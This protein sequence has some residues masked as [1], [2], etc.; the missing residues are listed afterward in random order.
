MVA[1][2]ADLHG[3][4]TATQALEKD[5]LRRGITRIWCLGDVVGKGPSS[6]RCFDWAMQNCE[7]ILRGNWEDGIGR[8]LFKNDAFYRAQLGRA[9]LDAML[10]FP[11]E[12]H[13]QLAGRRLRLLHGRPAL[14]GLLMPEDREE[15]LNP[16]FEPD[17]DIVGYADCHRPGL[18][19][20]H[21][22]L[23]NTGSVGNGFG[24]LTAQYAILET[25]GDDRLSPI[26]LCFVSLPYDREEA[27]R[28]TFAQPQL[29]LGH[30]YVQEIRIGRYA[31]G[32]KHNRDS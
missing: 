27:V 8:E 28:E 9:R 2:I 14:K 22:L 18:R 3:N 19:T 26:D 4:Y 12:K 25:S 24:T 13:L 6:D 17:F 15:L 1:I 21:G 16:L 20:L 23:F 30:L 29:P 7:F 10:Q 31:R 32:K 11:L 5:L